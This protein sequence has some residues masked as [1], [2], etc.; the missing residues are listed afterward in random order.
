MSSTRSLSP[1]A[2][3]TEAGAPW[4]E[5]GLLLVGHG[6]S[7]LAVATYLLQAHAENLAARGLFGAVAAGF[8]RGAPSVEE[9]LASLP[10]RIV[11]V[12]PFFLGRGYFTEVAVPGRVGLSSSVNCLHE[13]GNRLLAYCEPVGCSPRFDAALAAMGRH[14]CAAEGLPVNSTTLLV[15]GHGNANL[16]TASETLRQHTET[17]AATG[18]FAAVR[19]AFIEE[20]P[21]IG[22]ALAELTDGDVVV[23][24]A[25]AGLGHHALDDIPDAVSAEKARRGPGSAILAYAG[26]IGS[27]PAMADLILDRVEAFENGLVG[28]STSPVRPRLRPVALTPPGARATFGRPRPAPRP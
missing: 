17:I 5:A 10:Q 3:A 11:C 26:I 8:L 27:D 28:S 18:E 15:V 2:Q 9:A 6:S 22:E 24:G 4:R 7:D 23:I 25:L 16:A 20:T 12:V 1:P 21:L 19:A 13:V 14:A